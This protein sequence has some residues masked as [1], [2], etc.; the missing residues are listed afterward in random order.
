VRAAAVEAVGPLTSLF[1]KHTHRTK[2]RDRNRRRTTRRCQNAIREELAAH[3]TQQL[4]RSRANLPVRATAVETTAVEIVGPL[5]SLFLKHTHTH[6][7]RR[8][9]I[10]IVV[11]PRD[12][13]R[14]PSAKS[15][16][17]AILNIMRNAL[18]QSNCASS[19]FAFACCSS[20]LD[21][22]AE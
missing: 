1:P 19:N 3:H 18:D 15:P 10:E 22:P 12:D 16:Q 7:H 17:L 9:E 11:G 20:L 5:T 4:K 13:A 21:T 6:T 8:G 2:G 14:A